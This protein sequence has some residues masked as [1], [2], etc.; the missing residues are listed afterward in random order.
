MP[1][2]FGGRRDSAHIDL[3]IEEPSWAKHV[4]NTKMLRSNILRLRWWK[5]ETKNRRQR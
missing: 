4:V 1:K 2:V 5:D 3:L